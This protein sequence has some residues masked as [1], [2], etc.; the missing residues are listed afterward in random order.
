MSNMS[1]LQEVDPDDK[2]V[3]HIEID[4]TESG[5]DFRPGD[6][7][8]IIPENDAEEV[9]SI[10]KNLGWDPEEQVCIASLLIPA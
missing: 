10:I 6:W 2:E 5:I 7:V 8:S 3:Y 1:V 4:I 9:D